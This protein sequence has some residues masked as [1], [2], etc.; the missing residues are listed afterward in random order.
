MLIATNGYSGRLTPW[1]PIRPAPIS[2]FMIT[3]E[4]VSDNLAKSSCRYTPIPPTG[5][6]YRERVFLF[7]QL[8]SVKIA[9]PWNG[10][11]TA[12]WDYF[13]RTGVRNGMHYSLGY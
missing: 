2:A 7:A 1:T 9:R 3:T 5:A 4:P 12:T 6:A 11:C 10:G 8:E 13:P